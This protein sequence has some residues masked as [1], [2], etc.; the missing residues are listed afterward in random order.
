MIREL[1]KLTLGLYGVH[2][3]AIEADTLQVLVDDLKVSDAPIISSNL[4]EAIAGMY[5]ESVGNSLEVSFDWSALHA[6]PEQA[7]GG[8]IRIQRDYFSR[9]EEVRRELR[10]LELEADD[11]FIGTVERLDGT[12]AAGPEMSFLRFCFPTKERQFAPRFHCPRT[13]MRTRLQL[14]ERTE[15]MCA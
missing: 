6:V 2:A 13:T 9:V 5:D 1:F 7:K 3:S 14:T 12:M 8:R 4:C 15:P 11:T 10:A